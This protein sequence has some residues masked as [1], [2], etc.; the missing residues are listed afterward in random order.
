MCLHLPVLQ[1]GVAAMYWGLEA[2]SVSFA[3]RKSK[4]GAAGEAWTES[5]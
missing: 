1:A 4:G 2:A 5:D 3:E